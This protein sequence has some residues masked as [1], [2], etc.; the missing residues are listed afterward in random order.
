MIGKT[1]RVSENETQSFEVI[2][3]PT[4]QMIRAFPDRANARKQANF[5]NGGNG[6]N[7]WTP[8][9]ILRGIQ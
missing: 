9:F 5:L 2:E 3:Q 1:Y 8:P 7:G 4:Q 6:F